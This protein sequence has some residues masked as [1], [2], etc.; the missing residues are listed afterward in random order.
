M[1]NDIVFEI[2]LLALVFSDQKRTSFRSLRSENVNIN[3]TDSLTEKGCMGLG[4]LAKNYHMKQ[5]IINRGPNKRFTVVRY[6][7]KYSEILSP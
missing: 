1:L 5:T 7:L 4:D 2:S 3:R 6:N